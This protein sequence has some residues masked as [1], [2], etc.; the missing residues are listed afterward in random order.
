MAYKSWMRVCTIFL[1]IAFI[2]GSVISL[3]HAAPGEQIYNTYCANCHGAK[4]KGDGPAGASLNPKPANFTD[5]KVMKSRSDND[6]VTIVKKGGAAVG[7][8]P[9]MMPWGTQ[10]SDGQIKEVVSYIRRFCK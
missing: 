3:A 6:L 8:S 4:G 10:L 5:C 9:L 7:R 2:L 1:C